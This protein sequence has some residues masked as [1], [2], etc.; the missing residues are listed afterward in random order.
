MVTTLRADVQRGSDRAVQA[1]GRNTLFCAA[2]V[3]RERA[4]DQ[5]VGY[6][7]AST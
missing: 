3:H 2:Y 6:G 4:P 7:V 5:P 1:L